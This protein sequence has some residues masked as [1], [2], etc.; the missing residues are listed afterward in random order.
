[1]TDNRDN[2]VK[3]VPASLTPE[4]V[5]QLCDMIIA[6]LEA[7]NLWGPAFQAGC[8]GFESRLPLQ[9]LKLKKPRRK[10]EWFTI[11]CFCTS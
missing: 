10:N 8:R 5:D 6:R 9:F 2:R 7:R 11:S 1:M 4:V 3:R